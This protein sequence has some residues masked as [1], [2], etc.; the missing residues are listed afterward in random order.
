MVC[1]STILLKIFKNMPNIIDSRLPLPVQAWPFRYLQP[2]V[3]RQPGYRRE[4]VEQTQWTR[5]KERGRP[6]NTETNK[7]KKKDGE[8]KDEMSE[9][10]YEAWVLQKCRFLF[11][12]CFLQFWNLKVAVDFD[13][14]VTYH[15][16]RH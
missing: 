8:Y 1:H 14:Q 16:K 4:A 2:A 13:L 11:F 6:K 12:V 15:F 7:R 10:K 3:N 9:Q 5:N